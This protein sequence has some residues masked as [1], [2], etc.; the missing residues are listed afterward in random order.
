[1]GQKFMYLFSEQKRPIM[2]ENELICLQYIFFE[3]G[4]DVATECR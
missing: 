4:T 2:K 3:L 1:M